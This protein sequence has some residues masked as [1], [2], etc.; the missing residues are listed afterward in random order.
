MRFVLRTLLA[1]LLSAGPCTVI[2][3]P[4]MQPGL[5]E[6]QTTTEI[7]GMPAGIGVPAITLQHCF[8]ANDVAQNKAMEPQQGDCRLTHM[9]QTGDDITWSMQCTGEQALTI[10]GNGTFSGTHYQVSNRMTMH[11]GMMAGQTLTSTVKARLL[12]P[13]P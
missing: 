13:C 2:A 3:A 9:Q 12:G 10:E 8:T 11:G 6:M 4:N 5:W 7:P 1:T